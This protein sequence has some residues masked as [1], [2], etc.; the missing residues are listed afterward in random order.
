MKKIILVI[1][2]I[3]PVGIFIF[4]RFFGKNEFAI[5]VYYENAIDIPNTGCGR[6]YSATYQVAD[7]TL[8]NIGWSGKSV[9]IV[10]DSSSTVHLGLKRLNEELPNEVQLIFLPDSEA[11][12]SQLFRCDFLLQKPMNTVLLDEQRRIRGYYDYKDREEV[13]RLILELKIL[14]KKY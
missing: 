11:Y 6:S 8:T 1:T 12:P 9:L 10:N 3:V 4:L 5:P 14:L 2:L 13:D 7:S